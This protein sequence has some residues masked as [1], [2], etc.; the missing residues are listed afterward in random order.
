M[1]ANQ[2]QPDEC[3]EAFEKWAITQEWIA[4]VK[5]HEPFSRECYPDGD[6][7]ITVVRAAWA[8]WNRRSTNE[9]QDGLTEDEIWKIAEQTLNSRTIKAS[10]GYDIHFFARAI[11]RHLSIKQ[12]TIPGNATM[13]DPDDAAFP[14]GFMPVDA[15]AQE[16]NA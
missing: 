12:A 1:T 11:A 14:K 15:P 9:G 7:D 16:G 13:Y 5:N 10:S 3:R 4:P 6:Y 2:N 8:A